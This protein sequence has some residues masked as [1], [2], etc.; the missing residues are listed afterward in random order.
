MI[1]VAR[2][3]VAQT[4][5]PEVDPTVTGLEPR[6]LDGPDGAEGDADTPDGGAR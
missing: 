3:A 5:Y 2:A 6:E 1:T 4:A